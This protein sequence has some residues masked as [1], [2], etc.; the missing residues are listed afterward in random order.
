MKKSAL[1]QHPNLIKHQSGVTLVELSIVLTII[2]LLIGG[3][4]TGTTIMKTMEL[5]SI[6]T[7]YQHYEVAVTTFKT[8]YNQLPG[9]FSNAATVWGMAP[10][11]ASP[12][13][14]D[15]DCADLINTDLSEGTR[16]CNGNGS[17]TIDVGYEEFRAWQHLVNAGM[18][19]GAFTGLGAT[20]TAGEGFETG[21][22][23]PSSAFGQSCWRV[24]YLSSE[25]ADLD[26]F[27]LFYG[28]YDAHAFS[29]WGGN[30]GPARYNPTLT[31]S[32]MAELDN[33]YD[34]GKPATG[35]VFAPHGGTAGAAPFDN[36]TAQDGSTAEATATDDDAVYRTNTN[37]RE[38]QF[39]ARASF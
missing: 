29:L 32:E 2:A 39:Y 38:C 3:V 10:T 16:T 30:T 21:L 31:P 22:N 24:F 36:C 33:K 5:R 8:K 27:T 19:E 28:K 18:I 25:D 12:A 23:C 13:G 26:D 20:A 14:D 6:M 11:A 34:D 7:E 17:S 9:D 37:L 1:N 15:D 4:L 35:K